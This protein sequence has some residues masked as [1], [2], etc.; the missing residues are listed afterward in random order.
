MWKKNEIG[1]WTYKTYEYIY[2]TDYLAN[3]ATT[4]VIETEYANTLRRL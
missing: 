2:K 4:Y 1:K 3:L